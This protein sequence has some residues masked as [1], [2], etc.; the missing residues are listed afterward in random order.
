MTPHERELERKRRYYRKNRKR[1][2][3]AQKKRRDDDP[4]YKKQRAAWGRAWRARPGYNATRRLQRVRLRALQ[5]HSQ[6]VERWQRRLTG[7]AA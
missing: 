5:L 7:W 2:L 4:A 3:A 6:R 1:I